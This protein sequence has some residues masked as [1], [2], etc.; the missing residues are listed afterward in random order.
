MLNFCLAI[1]FIVMKLLVID[2]KV[3]DEI[4]DYKYAIE[5]VEEAFKNKE[6]YGVEL[7]PRQEI[8]LDAPQRFYGSMAAYL[9]GYNIIGVKLITYFF[10]NPELYRI[11]PLYAFVS[12]FDGI[13]GVPLAIVEG[14]KVTTY[15]TG[16]MGA[17]SSKY[18]AVKT[19]SVIGLIGAGIQGMMQLHMHLTLYPS[20]D[21][22]LVYDALKDKA[23]SL[24]NKFSEQYD[25]E[26]KSVDDANEVVSKS[27]I[28]I[29]AT[30]SVKPV[31]DGKYL[32]KGVHIVSIGYIN[33]DSRELD[34][35][36]M[37]RASKIYV[38]SKD[39]YSSGDIRIPLEKGV[40][41]K[42]KVVGELSQVIVGRVIGRESDK[43]ITIFKSVGTAILDA[44][45]AYKIY[46][47]AVEKGKGRYI[48]L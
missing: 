43:E 11:P 21:R 6:I 10:E 15:R 45:M 9:H 22:V 26:F 29:T 25:I 20:V 35:N 36:S 33:K 34:D 18:L 13:K 12:I 2:S 39:A 23:V 40:I 27:D 30:T 31:L 7:P 3:I 17:V 16:A 42:S 48:E 38:D 28:L 5:V 24:I 14:T 47:K 8:T 4:I 41:H 1:K 32:K 19:P 37:A 46:L 44:A